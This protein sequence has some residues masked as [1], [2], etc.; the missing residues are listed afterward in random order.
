MLAQVAEYGEKMVGFIKACVKT[1]SRGGGKKVSAYSSSSSS[2]SSPEK[3]QPSSPSSAAYVK[4]ACIL[5]LRV[6]P[7]HRYCGRPESFFA[8]GSACLFF[9]FEMV[10]IHII[11][12][13]FSAQF[14]TYFAGLPNRAWVHR[15]G[16]VC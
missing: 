2:S 7:S 15:Y 13:R 12:H 9:S 14:Q 11:A 5:G 16:V 8:L 4:V 1:V 6:S 3:L 10:R